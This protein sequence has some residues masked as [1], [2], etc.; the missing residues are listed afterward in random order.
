MA[1]DRRN[2]LPLFLLALLAGLLV[3]LAI[4]ARAA[5]RLVE[6][7]PGPDSP[8]VP[9]GSPIV[10]TFNRPMDSASVEA[11]LHITP[12]V[13]GMLAWE[14]TQLTFRP[15]QAWPAGTTVTVRLAAGARSVLVLPLLASSE[16]S[17]T[18]GAPRLAYLWP[19]GGPAELYARTADGSQTEQLTSSAYGVVDFEVSA[20]GRRVL[21]AAARADGGVDLWLLEPGRPAHTRLY[22]CPFAHRCT[23]AT[24]SPD[25]AWLA[26]EHLEP[27]AAGA[28][29]RLAVGRIWL[30]NTADGEALA[31]SPEERA[32]SMP[33]WSSDGRLAYFD[34]G[35]RAIVVVEPGRPA[36]TVA[37]FA[38]E[39]GPAGSW[40]PD[41]RY[42]LFPEIEFPEAGA[43]GATPVAPFYS[44]LLRAGIQTGEVVELWNAAIGM[45]ED[46]Q[47]TYSPDGLWIAFA[48]RSLEPARWTLGRQLWLMR[49]DGGGARPLTDEPTHSHSAF[50]WS[51]DSTR[52]AYMRF[53]EADP[54]QAAEIW[55]T[56]IEAPAPLRLVIGGY[57]PQWLP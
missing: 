31:L 3:S 45:V 44:H 29:P 19:A 2:R 54:T 37:T 14:G 7:S 4:A 40:S 36:R 11:R 20:D 42:L 49:A 53:N 13:P 55:W 22:A 6:V 25:G 27:E 1:F 18:V 56:T 38:S 5:P 52:L 24:L 9:T 8:H 12:A 34:G 15:D 35:L 26:F 39:L 48:R 23:A 33:L 47:P 30:V 41:G 50:A 16:W 28:G 10:L 17:F 51:P 32:A 21:Y 46:S 57:L 43:D